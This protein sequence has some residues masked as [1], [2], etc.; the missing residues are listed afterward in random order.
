MNAFHPSRIVLGLATLGMTAGATIAATI[1][2]PDDYSTIQAAIDAAANRDTVVVRNGNW[3]G[4]GNRDLDFK[5][6]AITV[7]SDKGPSYCIIDCEDSG[8]AFY[9]HN[10][11]TQSSVVQG[12]TI[13]NGNA[14]RGGAIYCERSDPLITDCVITSN[15]VNE[16]WAYGAGIYTDAASPTIRRCTITSNEIPSGL[17]RMGAGVYCDGGAP[18]IVDSAIRENAISGPNWCYGA[19]IYCRGGSADIQDC[20]FADNTVS[21]QSWNFG[22]GLFL[23][24]GTPYVASST[25]G[26]N[27][28]TGGKWT[29]GGAIYIRGGDPVVTSCLFNRNNCN[30]GTWAKGGAVCND[31]GTPTLTNC[32]L[33]D[34]WAYAPTYA[35][36]RGGGLYTTRGETTVTNGLAWENKDNTGT[37]ESAQICRDGSLVV[38]YTSLQEWTGAYGG[39]ANDGVDPLF[40]DPDGPD[41]NAA[42]W[43][44]NDFHLS[45]ASPSI[46][47]GDN[48]APGLSPWDFERDPRVAD[49]DADLL[50]VVD[51]GA[52]EYGMA[53]LW[54]ED[55]DGSDGYPAGWTI[56]RK[57]ADLDV[58]IE[59]SEEHALSGPKSLRVSGPREDGYGNWV[60][61]DDAGVNELGPYRIRLSIFYEPD[62]EG[63]YQQLK[64]F[65]WFRLLKF[66]PV[67][68]VMDKWNL[69]LTYYNHTGRHR[70]GTRSLHD[71]C[72]PGEWCNF[73]IEVDPPLQSYDVYED[74]EYI[75]T[76]R[77]AQH[78]TGQDGYYFCEVGGDA[79]CEPDYLSNGFLDD[80][81]IEQSLAWSLEGGDCN[82][83]GVADS[84]DISM[85][86]SSDCNG[87]GIPDE[88]QSDCNANGM[89]DDCDI[90]AFSSLDC[91]TNG[92]P[93][94]C[95]PDCN[96]NGVPDDCDLAFGAS[97][98]CNGNGVPDDCEWITG[99][100][101]QTGYGAGCASP[102]I[103]ECVCQVDP[104]CCQQEWD[105]RCV[106]LVVTAGCGVCAGDA[107]GNGTFDECED[108][109]SDSE[110]NCCDDDDDGDGALDVSDNCPLAWTETQTDT[111]NDGVGD[112]CDNCVNAPNPAQFDSD[113]DG[114]GDCC[115]SDEPDWD[116]DGV[117]D[118]CD[119]CPSTGN[120]GQEDSDGDGAGD[121]C[122]VCNGGL[123]DL[124]AD[125]DRVANFCDNCPDVPNADGQEDDGDG[126]GVGDACDNC[127]EVPNP[128]Q[129]DTDHDGVGD[130]CDNCPLTGNWGQEDVN[131]D[132]VGDVCDCNANGRADLTDIAE[133]TSTDCDGNGIPSECELGD[134]NGDL[135]VD[136]TDYEAFRLC[137]SG[138]GG[139]LGTGCD[140]GDFDCDNDID[141]HDFAAFQYAL[142]AF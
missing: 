23:D 79:P 65:H 41:N 33:Y 103:E 135:T 50:A 127:E 16:Q 94:E 112:A 60:T 121:A 118:A 111:D 3:T 61:A 137:Y 87:D 128:N 120:W 126:D 17:W 9:F 45:A 116:G 2:V 69:K 68:L 70:L 113:A 32:T 31:G 97:S 110:I 27:A 49:G 36:G 25:F 46:D 73:R 64:G 83:N 101:C 124:D 53:V 40:V 80:L 56:S 95:E 141:L 5:G 125:G 12:F 35:W 92:V 20:L 138:P 39:T 67:D 122:D 7:R 75:G 14:W 130:A 123:D 77:Y 66:G 22:A 54:S 131:S 15:E 89:H 18:V 78:D 26:G 76:V 91:N 107:N 82:M 47:T 134:F 105:A 6:K 119:N 140:A 24:E 133:G 57:A 114:A 59:L 4:L 96:A 132:G 34:N 90:S 86:P 29:H 84:I 30:N 51:R 81:F 38:N 98:D 100:C 10:G 43:E 1:Y 72:P 99:D 62:T 117:S 42:T 136:I 52:D 74:E 139:S 44:D 102:G 8:R 58:A 21:G 109:N 93:D 115:D 104:H 106:S 88:C 142:P 129:A 13:K 19:G 71:Y 55:F 85:G 28:A 48:V 108:F 37:N 63:E 11:E